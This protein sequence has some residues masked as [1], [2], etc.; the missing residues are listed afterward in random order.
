MEVFS[1]LFEMEASLEEIRTMLE[2]EPSESLIKRQDALLTEY[3]AAGGLIYKSRA[4]GA[5]IGLGFSESDFGR[6]FSSLSGGEKTRLLL[7]RLLLGR[8]RLLLL[9]EPT[10]HLDMA[11][12]RWLEGFLRSYSGSYI[13]ISHD[14]YFLDKTTDVTLGLSQARITS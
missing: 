8:H 7:A 5:L 1:H 10:N 2:K 12:V 6:P 13:V 9:D 11:S 3:E 14:R 4:R